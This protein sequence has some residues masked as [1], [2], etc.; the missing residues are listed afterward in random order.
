MVVTNDGPADALNSK[1]VD[2]LPG[3]LAF[4][5]IDDTT[6]CVVTGQVIECDFGT[7]AAGDARTIHVTAKLDGA[8]TTP[9][10]NV[11][12]VT[13]TTTAEQHDANNRAKASNDVVPKADVWIEKFADGAVFDG[14]ETVTYS[15]VA[16]NAGPS[17]AQGV[18]IDAD[19]PAGV[20]FASVTPG[21]PICAYAA[22]HVHCDL[23]ALAA[24]ADRTVTIV[25][26]SN[27]AA[28][29]SIGA[30]SGHTTTMSNV[31]QTLTL[32]PGETKTED[33]TVPRRR[34]RIGRL[35]AHPGERL[36]VRGA[37]RAQARSIARGTYRFV[38]TSDVSADVPIRLVVT[39]LP[40][41]T[42]AG[43]HDHQLDV[44]ALRTLTTGPLPPGRHVR[45]IPGPPDQLAV[46]RHRRG[47]G[48]S[49]AR[50]QRARRQRSHVH[51]RGARDRGRD[52]Q[53]PRLDYYTAPGWRARSCARSRL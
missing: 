33:V 53:R 5:S 32:A 51:R 46:A 29:G 11:V 47:L 44:G 14:G 15:L 16:H 18:T 9:I 30:T 26:T 4:V 13:T 50:R 52:A 36:A 6:H 7:L 12:D 1:L 40:R 28:A 2:T 8:R 17:V 39:C 41:K 35:G 19:I 31:E 38:V 10:K 21:A 48:H 43:P 20:T 27:S 34:Q 3:Y 23:G 22:G 49:P 45:T 25:T 42:D 24:G 37:R